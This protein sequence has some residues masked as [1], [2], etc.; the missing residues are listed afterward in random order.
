MRRNDFQ[1]LLHIY[2]CISLLLFQFA[3]SWLNKFISF[4]KFFHPVAAWNIFQ[5]F[6]RKLLYFILVK[7]N[8]PLNQPPGTW[9]L[10]PIKI[11]YQAIK[12]L[13][14]I[15]ILFIRR[16]VRMNKGLEK[17]VEVSK[18]RFLLL[19]KINILT[20]V[21]NASTVTHNLN[22]LGSIKMFFKK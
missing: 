5:I 1:H 3:Y 12:P 2:F 16:N 9:G 4:S 19:T 6:I 13:N 20:V 15:P 18:S 11:L 10:L 14:V 17:R 8:I 21:N 22:S 7:F